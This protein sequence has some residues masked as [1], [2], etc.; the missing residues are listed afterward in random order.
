MWLNLLDGL[1]IDSLSCTGQKEVNKIYGN[2]TRIVSQG[3][4]I[5]LTGRNDKGVLFS[6]F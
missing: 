5:N 3:L 6:R 1:V 4:L 2:D